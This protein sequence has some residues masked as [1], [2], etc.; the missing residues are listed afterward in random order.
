VEFGRHA[1]IKTLSNAEVESIAGEAGRYRVH[2]RKRPRYVDED[3]CTACGSCVD[4]CPVEQPDPY[5]ENLAKRKS[6]YIPYPQAVPASYVIDPESC[7][8]VVKKE[9]RQCEQACKELKAIDLNQQEERL[10]VEVG[11]V[12][13]CPGFDEYN[14]RKKKDYGYGEYPNVITSI[15][16]ERILS[17]SG[18][19]LGRVTRPSDSA[20]PGRIAFL[21]CVGSRDVSA[22]AYCSSVCCTVAVKEAIIAKEHDAG[23]EISLFYMDIRTQG[24]GFES[25]LERAKNEFGIRFVKSRLASLER[26]LETENLFLNYVTE[27]GEHRREEF[28]LVVLSVGLEPSKTARELAGNLGFRLNA[29]RF[30]HTLEFSPMHTSREGIFVAGA[31]Q[32]PKDI[33]ESVTQASGSVSLASALL[34]DARGT[35]IE[36]REPV[37]E[38]DVEGQG[39]RVGVFICH[40]GVNVA[41]VADVSRLK[42][43]AEGLDDVVYAG[44]S[45]YACSRDSQETIKQ[46]IGEHR[47]NRVVLAACT[48]RTHEPLFQETLREAGLN[49][50]L[51]EMANIRDQCTWVHAGEH[52]AATEKAR[53]LI[54]MGVAKSRL[55]SPMKEETLPVVPRGLVIGGGLSGMTAALA[56]AEQGF[57]CYLVEKEEELG[58]N[59]RKIH[60]TLKNSDPQG[61]LRETVERVT[62]SERIRVFTRAEIRSLDGYIGNFRTR[63][64]ANGKEE[65]LSHGVIIVASGAREY[66]PEEYLHGKHERVITQKK[67]E[68]KLA[69]GK[70]T[71]SELEHV[72]MIQCVGSRTR[73]RPW[74]S[75][76]CCAAAIKNALKIKELHPA[77]NIYIFYKDIRTYGLGEEFFSRARR[78]GILFIHYD[79]DS[80]PEV[81]EEG[82]SLRVTAFDALLGERIRIHPSLI[83]LSAAVVP[84]ANE[85]ISRLLKVPLNP[86]GFFQEAHVKLRPVDFATDGIYLCGLA[87][88]PKPIEESICQARAAA[89]RA[90]I[91]L[92]RGHVM[93]E[94]IV[95]SVDP[96]KCFG[97]GICE[98]L[99]PYGSI[100]VVATESGE[101]A[102]TVSASCK[103]CG[104]CASKCPRQAIAMGGFTREQILSQI[105]AFAAEEKEEKG[106][107]EGI[108]T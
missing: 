7:L 41:G 82:G 40:C 11:S 87:H 29:D 3:R 39:P 56:L 84:G 1:N 14:A 30:C 88:S 50:C 104:I 68:E 6:L 16:F 86:E 90:S 49:R 108:S 96:V 74:C 2:V 59:L 76:I 44:E 80:R 12:I 32:S 15:E 52:G 105:Q 89:A 24:K 57:D 66:S 85:G 83:V 10:E 20:V 78:E 64:A 48:P 99:C 19:F 33:P 35:L 36:K 58:G 102:R 100:K 70:S 75:K 5:N 45:L 18:P 23:L 106:S 65:E 98:Y 94:P 67:L 72:V 4:Y 71:S 61:L 93:V 37:P 43:Y 46:V 73:E 34:T 25:F 77:S 22:N 107:R 62:G 51:F 17:A 91:P 28:D 38:T 42:E 27:G 47:L 55:L 101:K 103:G 81:T 8:F 69:G 92:A 97:C 9:C 53:D 54:R 21:Q 95:S 63:I 26:S 60:Y 79:D 13:L 31:F